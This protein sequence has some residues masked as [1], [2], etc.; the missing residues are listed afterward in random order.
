MLYVLALGTPAL[1]ALFLLWRLRNFLLAASCLLLAVIPP[2]AWIT[3]QCQLTA[4][5]QA[6]I[7]EKATLPAGMTFAAVVVAPLLYL[8]ASAVM[9]LRQ[10]WR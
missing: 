3:L 6:C 5:E 4:T 7:W 8:A 2:W 10:R 1:L 9:T